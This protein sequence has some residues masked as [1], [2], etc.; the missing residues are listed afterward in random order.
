VILMPRRWVDFQHYKNRAPPWIKL[1]RSLLDDYE[2]HCLPVA[3]RALAP[4]LWLIASESM[5]GSFDAAPDRLGFRL[6]QTTKEI[7]TA[8]KPLIEKGFFEVVRNA[9]ETLADCKRDA[10]LETEGEGEREEEGETEA[11]TLSGKPDR[12]AEVIAHLNA[13]AGTR[14]IP[15]GANAKL[16]N[17]RLKEGLSVQTLKAIATKK[18]AEWGKDAKWAQYLRPATLYGAEKCHQYAGQLGIESAAE[19][20]A[21]EDAEWLAN[22]AGIGGW[23]P[24]NGQDLI[25]EFEVVQ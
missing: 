20:K 9:S 22:P 13:T 11:D 17:A 3:S 23:G 5:D 18:H 7:E 21:R 2:Y 24:S 1:Q 25:G 6:R 16:I 4:L 14:F 15:K 12:A 19:R 8:I 10:C